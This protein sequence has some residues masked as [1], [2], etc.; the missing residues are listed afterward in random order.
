M[1]GKKGP[2]FY[3]LKVVT[4]DDE[5]YTTHDWVEGAAFFWVVY[6]YINWGILPPQKR[7]ILIN[8]R[9]LSDSL[10]DIQPQSQLGSKKF[11]FARRISVSTTGFS[12]TSCNDGKKHQ[13]EKL[14]RA[15]KHW[16]DWENEIGHAWFIHVC[17]Q[18]LI[19]PIQMMANHRMMK[20][21]KKRVLPISR[22]VKLY[23]VLV[24][25]SIDFLLRLFNDLLTS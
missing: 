16:K 18:T 21:V 14:L 19:E 7:E 24:K 5:H 15:N 2:S 23:R 4:R 6:P 11:G 9:H 1:Q 13:I 22:S 10:W 17:Q 3:P 12:P 25:L 20:R 8:E